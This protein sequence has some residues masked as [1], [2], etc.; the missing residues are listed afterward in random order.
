[1]KIPK[2]VKL[3]SGVYRIQLKLGGKS[4]MAYGDT[5]AQCKKQAALIKSEHLAG[6]VIQTKCRYTVSEAIDQY[7]ADKKLSPSTVRG[8]RSIQKNVFQTAIP[9]MADSINWQKVIDN[10]QHSPKTVKNAWGLIKSV[11]KHI[12][13]TPPEVT[14]PA[15]VSN[16]RDFLQ[17]EQISPFLDAMRGNECEIAALLGLHSLRRSEILDV[18]FA[19]VD[20][21][22]GIIN[23]RGAAVVDENGDLVHKTENKDATSTREVPIMIPRL[24][25]LLTE[26]FKEATDY[27][28]TC[29][30]NKIYKAVNAAC[31]AKGL[32]LIGVHGLRHSFVSLAYHLGWSE[33]TTMRVAGYADYNTMRK[34]YTHLAESDK[35]KDVSDMKKFFAAQTRNSSAAKKSARSQ[36][37]EKSRSDLVEKSM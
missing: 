5:E 8:Y 13:I 15:V 28:V 35:N 20:L 24:T 14:L 16:E 11:L 6:K 9:Q 7:I 21:D 12:G 2:P 34:I 37:K 22:K 31:E 30:P 25:E 26:N 19:D 4:I 29:Y 36:S 33:L 18:T 32:P 27:L 23:V 10:D 17:P 3:K 1:M